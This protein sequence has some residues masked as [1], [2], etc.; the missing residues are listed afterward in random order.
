[1]KEQNGDIRDYYLHNLSEFR[2]Y[3]L[4]YIDES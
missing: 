1:M 3:Y 2:L 4:V